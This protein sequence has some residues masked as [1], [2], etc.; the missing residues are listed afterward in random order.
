MNE[1][2]LKFKSAINELSGSHLVTAQEFDN[3]PKVDPLKLIK[4]YDSYEWELFIDEWVHSLKTK[5]VDVKILEGG[6]DKGIDV[7]GC[8]D[9]DLLAGV[10]D[11]YQ[12]KH[13]GRPLSFSV[14]APEI[15][16]IL[17]YSFCEIYKAPRAYKFVAPM[18]ASTS[19]SL[20]LANAGQ[21]KEKVISD[22]DKSVGNKITAT[23][24]IPLEGNFETYVRGFDFK[25]F[26]APQSRTIIEQHK[27]TQYYSGRF[28][29]GLPSRPLV[30]SPPDEIGKYETSYTKKLFDAYADHT[31]EAIQ[32]LSDL[33]KLTKL[34]EHFGRSREAFYHAESFRVFVREKT[35]PGTFESFQE[36]IY[37]GVVDTHESNHGDGYGRVVAV[38]ERAQSLALDAHPLNKSA[39]QKDR[40]GVCQQLANDGRLTWKK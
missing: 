25:I 24:N 7:A 35:E 1:P 39:F 16:K 28:G 14:A 30:E 37:E 19:L 11:N 10:W 40:R 13:Y 4:T 18:G 17:W 12:C 21:L 32:S 29:G 27:S 5:Y 22:W 33:S 8:A 2:T 9:S 6:S 23:R 36:E 15:G 3:G 26:S 20:L 31:G 34:K 38:T